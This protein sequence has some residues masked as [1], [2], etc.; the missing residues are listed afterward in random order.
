MGDTSSTAFKQA[1]LSAAELLLKFA[2]PLYEMDGTRPKL[3]GTGFLVHYSGKNFLISAAHVLEG[4]KERPL[5]YYVAPNITRKLTGKLAVTH[6][7]GPRKLDPID[8]GVLL[9]D[10]E[11]QPPYPKVGKFAA[12]FSYLKPTLLPRAEKQYLLIG[13]PGSRSKANPSAKEVSVAPY[14]YWCLSAPEASYAATGHS[15]TNH[16][17][18]PLD[19]KQGYDLDGAKCAFP[20]PHGMSGS[21]IVML[22]DE[23][24][25]ND[26][27]TFPIVGIATT[28]LKEKNL[29]IATDI[30]FAVDL[31]RN[32][33][34]FWN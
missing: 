19:V 24:G 13:F 6:F 12:D 1:L 27:H 29:I 34:E 11:A 31:I 20:K 16:L 18:L 17:L 33:R 25:E 2:V 7:D 32:T 21:P 8:V 10:G 26:P 9:L 22:Y 3:F 30:R 5:R 14:S 4:I 15:V 28:Y 23:T